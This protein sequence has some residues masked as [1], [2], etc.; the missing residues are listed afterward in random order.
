MKRNQLEN[1]K[2]QAGNGKRMRRE[3][4]QEGNEI[5]R[6]KLEKKGKRMGSEQDGYKAEMKEEWGWIENKNEKGV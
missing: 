1:G 5:M 3:Q 6:R 4:E 2:K